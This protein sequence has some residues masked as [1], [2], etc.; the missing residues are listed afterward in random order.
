[1]ASDGRCLL[2]S[3]LQAT[4]SA[5]AA[6]QRA[7]VGMES[8]RKPQARGANKGATR[9]PSADAGPRVLRV[10]QT[11]EPL[12]ELGEVYRMGALGRDSESLRVWSTANQRTGRR[13]VANHAGVER[14][15]R[16]AAPTCTRFTRG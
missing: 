15:N 13:R 12:L 8:C 2:P 4:K 16:S 7:K 5:E 11:A 6:I 1:L 14:Q 10:E 9:L 3:E